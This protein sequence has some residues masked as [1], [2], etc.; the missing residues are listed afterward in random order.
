VEWTP[1]HF[2][3][4]WFETEGGAYWLIGTDEPFHIRELVLGDWLEEP[5]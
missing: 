1:A 4:D 2:T 3:P 5:V